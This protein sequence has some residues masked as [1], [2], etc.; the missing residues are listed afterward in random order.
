MIFNTKILTPA[1][2]LLLTPFFSG[3]DDSRPQQQEA[4]SN[5]YVINI[6]RIVEES[7]PVKQ[8]R[9]YIEALS[10]KLQHSADIVEK[11]YGEKGTAPSTVTYN[12]S[13][14]TL[15]SHFDKEREKSSREVLNAIQD[16]TNLW[17]KDK[18]KAVVITRQNVMANGYQADITGDIIRLMADVKF[19]IA[20]IPDITIKLPANQNSAGRPASKKKP[21]AVVND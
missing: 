20:D 3:C 15:R 18:P 13:I 11:V 10:K 1:A 7:P 5:V 4:E 16:K 17:L 19:N 8:L 21:A 12:S 9:S 6:E 2:V 14:H